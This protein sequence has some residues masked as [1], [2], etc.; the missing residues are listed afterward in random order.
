MV[1]QHP[2]GSQP[3]SQRCLEN[4]EPTPDPH[5]TECGTKARRWTKACPGPTCPLIAS[6]FLVSWAVS[7]HVP[8]GTAPTAAWLRP[9]SAWACGGSPRLRRR[10]G[11]YR[12]LGATPVPPHPQSHF[13]SLG[14]GGAR[15]RTHVGEGPGGAGTSGKG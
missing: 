11:Y 14:W 5:C 8:S 4:V 15:V 3:Q 9:S 2:G 10:G 7:F 12:A 6:S 1:S 13:P